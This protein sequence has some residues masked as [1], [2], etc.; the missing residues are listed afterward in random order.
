MGGQI[1]IEA[2]EAEFLGNPIGAQHLYLVHRDTNG[3]EYVIR[4]GPADTTF[5]F[6]TEMD[7]ETNIPIAQS[8]DARGSDTP[9]DRFSTLLDFPDLTTDQAWAIMVKYALKISDADY[10]YHLLT[11]NSNAFVGAMIAA[12]GG[13]PGAMLPNG[14]S[15]SDALGLT[16]Y[17][18]ILDDIRAP[19]NGTVVGTSRDDTIQGIQVGERIDA[20]GGSDT[21]RAGRGDDTVIGGNGND[22]LYGEFGFDT[23]R[24][25]NG[26]DR[27]Y[28]GA[29]GDPAEPDEATTV[30]ADQLFGN[31]G[32][33]RLFGSAARDL[34]FGGSGNDVIKGAGGNDLIDGGTGNNTLFGGAGADEFYFDEAAL[35]TDTIMDFKDG[36]D[37]IRIDGASVSGFDDLTLS[38]NGADVVIAF[39]STQIVLLDTNLQDIDADDFLFNQDE[40]MLA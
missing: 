6:F 5:P 22:R 31:G 33:D 26:N 32:R 16:S 36:I 37:R 7:V 21:V 34:L 8:S 38:R 30:L 12:A 35:S 14:I 29:S 28:A 39:A 13:M 20:R 2:D 11:V 15:S 23:L 9:Q 25:G 27:L 24:G 17:D 19:S 3:R 4:S 18:E 40:W 10:D 1:F